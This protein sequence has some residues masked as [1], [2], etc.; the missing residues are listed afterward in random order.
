MESSTLDMTIL[1]GPREM[2]RAI[3]LLHLYS[4]GLI[5]ARNMPRLARVYNA[6]SSDN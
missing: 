1:A 5:R 6:I 2:F 4:T 3:S